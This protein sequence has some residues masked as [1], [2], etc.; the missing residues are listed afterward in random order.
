[1]NEKTYTKEVD[2][3]KFYNELKSANSDATFHTWYDTAH[4][5]KVCFAESQPQ[6]V[7]DIIDLVVTNH[8]LKSLEKLGNGIVGPASNALFITSSFSGSDREKNSIILFLSIG[9]LRKSGRLAK[10]TIIFPAKFSPTI[11][12]WT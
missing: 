6:S 12:Y 3:T 11:F 4:R 1:M 8:V 9:F 10:L 5:V 2:T 7:W